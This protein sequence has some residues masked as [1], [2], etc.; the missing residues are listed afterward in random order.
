MTRRSPVVR[1]RVERTT[2]L[3]TDARDLRAAAAGPL[4]RRFPARWLDEHAVLPLALADGVARVAATGFLSVAVRDVLARHLDAEIEVVVHEA[5]EIR[6]ALLAAPRPSEAPAT[7]E[8]ADHDVA[9]DD[10]RAMASRE[11]VVQV[12]NALLAEAARA[13]ASDLH[14]ESTADGV[15]VRMRLDGVLHD[16][17]RLGPDFRAA[18]ISR[19]KV[20][21]ELDIAERRLPQDGRVRVRVGEQWLD[22]R[23]STLP[24]LHGESVVLRLLDAGGHDTAAPRSLESLGLHTSLLAPWRALVARS[25]GLLLVSGPTGSGKTTSLHAS[26]LERSTPDVKVVSVEDPVEYRL[27]SVVQLPANTRAGFGFP[28]ALRAILR[29]DPDVILVGEMRDAETAE[30]AVRAALTGHLVL[31]TVHTTD[32]VGAVARLLDMGVPPY[33]LTGTLQGVLAQRLVRRVCPACGV[34]REAHA[35][36][37]RMLDG[38]IERVFA[39]RGCA[40]CA[41]TGY[42]GRMAIAELLIVSDRMREAIAQSATSRTLHDIAR[43]EGMQLLAADGV[44]AVR[45]GHTTPEEVRRVVNVLHADIPA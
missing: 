42:R 12:V 39:G 17:Q 11:P 9:A 13:G 16:V 7:A 3:M 43:T 4:A 15:R 36:E 38:S 8:A 23:V 20:L 14:F 27:D 30:I 40:A 31:S 18:V 10:L 29:H 37:R 28:Q 44:R 19:L 35:E 45:D 21:A 2:A 25:A 5:A 34:W 24:A 32:A 6:A 22:V 1:R 41:Q 33:L 26:L